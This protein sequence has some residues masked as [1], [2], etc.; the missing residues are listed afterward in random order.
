GSLRRGVRAPLEGPRLRDERHPPA[1]GAPRPRGAGHRRVLALRPL[2]G[3]LRG[4]GARHL[5]ARGPC[6]PA[7]LRARPGGPADGGRDARRGLAPPASDAAGGPAP[8]AAR[9]A[10]DPPG[11]RAPRAGG[12]GPY[13]RVGD[14]LGAGPPR[15]L[16]RRR[17][18]R[19]VRPP[20]AG[21]GALFLALARLRGPRGLLHPALPALRPPPARAARRAAGAGDGRRPRGRRHPGAPP[22][23]RR[24]VPLLWR[25]AGR[26]APGVPPG[27]PG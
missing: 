8:R 11:L 4:A 17:D 18:A 23:E 14:A 25:P 13:A 22:R 12:L 24:P 20:H 2:A 7:S 1:P 15:G 27:A 26:R 21:A 9:A 16:P 6:V 10:A 3:D 5:A 19:R